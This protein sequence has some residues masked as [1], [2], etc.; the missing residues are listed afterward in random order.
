MDVDALRDDQWDRIKSFVPGG[1]KGK[2]VLGRTTAYFWMRY[3]GW[4]ARAVAGVTCPN[5]SATMGL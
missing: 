4:L 1:T 2:R 3:C 5:G